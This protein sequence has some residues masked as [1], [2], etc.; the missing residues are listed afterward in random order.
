MVVVRVSGVG[1]GVLVVWSVG[2]FAFFF[3]VV[4]GEMT[5][6]TTTTTVGN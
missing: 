4:F 6:L 3:P 2:V 5:M 1:F